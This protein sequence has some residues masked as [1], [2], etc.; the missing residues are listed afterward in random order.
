M[1]FVVGGIV[2]GILSLSSARPAG[3][4][5][6]TGF[7]EN[8]VTPSLINMTDAA[9]L[10][11]SGLLD[12]MNV[13]QG[14]DDFA[15]FILADMSSYLNTSPATSTTTSRKGLL[16]YR[17]QKEDTLS[18]IAANFGISVN[19]IIW[20]N[21]IA[22]SNLVR[23]GQEIVILPVSGILHEVRDGETLESIAKLYNVSPKKITT[24]N[25]D[26]KINQGDTVIVPNVKPIKDVIASDLPSV[27][28]YLK[29]PVEDGWN[30]GLLHDGG[31]VDISAA[32]G[33]PVYASAEG[34]V[35]EVGSPS[36]WNGG[37]GGYVRIKH[38]LYNI[39]TLY[40]HNSVNEVAVGDY[41]SQ[42]KEIAK[43]GKTGLVQGPTGCHVHFGVFGAKNP[44]AK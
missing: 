12:E 11:D 18:T 2:F 20:A 1:L 9:F 16:I 5:D 42:G 34:L 29:L 8:L 37:F 36:K 38:P 27:A 4:P 33:M 15:G 10:A 35:T 40:A 14:S 30:W 7:D 28:D 41:I 26:N 13:S 24:F 31:A 23:P 19:T 17:T 21:H 3:L 6:Y 22:N 43:I 39:E 32:C 44:F 25:K